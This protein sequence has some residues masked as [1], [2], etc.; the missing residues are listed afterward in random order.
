MMLGEEVNC[1]GEPVHARKAVAKKPLVIKEQESSTIIEDVFLTL[2]YLSEV[3]E[4][5]RFEVVSDIYDD[6]GELK[7]KVQ[8]NAGDLSS[9]I[10]KA[11]EIADKQGDDIEYVASEILDL[12]EMKK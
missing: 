6:E 10:E 7:I 12:H 11:R 2:K 1:W 8:V 3:I 9:V 4:P 5:S